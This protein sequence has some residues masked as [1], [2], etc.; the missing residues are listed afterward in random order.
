[1]KGSPKYAVTERLGNYLSP[2]LELPSE[3]KSLSNGIVKM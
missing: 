3:F 1:M 2:E